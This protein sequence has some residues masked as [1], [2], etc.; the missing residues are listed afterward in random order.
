MSAITA[1]NSQA[2]R[3]ELC[4]NLIEGGTTPSYGMIAVIRD[5][6]NIGIHVLIR[7]RG[8]DF[9]YDDQ[10]FEIMLKDIEICKKIGVEGIVAGVLNSDG[11]IDKDRTSGIVRTAY[12]MQVT[13]HRAFDLSA[14]PYKALEDIISC[15]ATRLLT[16]GQKN[17][18]FEGAELI[19]RLI[20]AS[21][22]RIIIMPGSGLNDSSIGAVA[23]ITKA[24]EFHF[25]GRK[26]I[27]SRMD[28]IRDGVYMGGN[29]EI[30]ENYRKVA[31][32]DLITRIRN[33]LENI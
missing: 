7:P 9:L 27:K 2:D 1:M 24:R 16:S 11:T 14:D 25:T 31:D 20:S 30:P 29:P 28:F 13:F 4:N 32:P 15:G 5:L 26:T 18:A 21:N 17:I 6:I 19:A 33:I 22:G 8:G 12:P 23:R 10:E 3:I